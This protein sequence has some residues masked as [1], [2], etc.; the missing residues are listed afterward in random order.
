[1]PAAAQAP[2]RRQRSGRRIGLT[3][4][5]RLLQWRYHGSTRLCIVGLS[6]MGSACLSGP[7]TALARPGVGQTRRW[8]DP[9]LARPGVGPTRHRLDPARIVDTFLP[10]CLAVTAR[11][12]VQGLMCTGP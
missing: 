3:R 2:Q 4:P 12:A 7:T 5:V 1:M 10:S 9:A 11:Y 6:H 8:P